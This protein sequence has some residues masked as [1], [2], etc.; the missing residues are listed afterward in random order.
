MFRGYIVKVVFNDFLLEEWYPCDDV[1]TFYDGVNKTSS[2]LGS[3]CGAIHPEVIYSTGQYLHVQFGTDN[4][5]N[6]RGFNLSF[7]AVKE[8][9]NM[10]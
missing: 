1:L 9:T 3:Y 4:M 5:V 6:Y 7:T 8:G 2:L 10:Q